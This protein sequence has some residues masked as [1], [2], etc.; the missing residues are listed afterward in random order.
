V[1]VSEGSGEL[2]LSSPVRFLKGVGP[3]RADAFARLGVLTAGDLLEYYPR[4]WV[5]APETEKIGRVIPGRAAA[6]PRSFAFPSA[7]VSRAGAPTGG[8]HS[9]S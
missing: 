7:S 1:T 6:G 9:R 8:P 4:D 3:A 5:F 2:G